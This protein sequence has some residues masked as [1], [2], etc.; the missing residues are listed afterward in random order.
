VRIARRVDIERYAFW[1]PTTGDPGAW[2][3]LRQA[4]IDDAA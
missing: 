4:D 2:N 1:A 3:V